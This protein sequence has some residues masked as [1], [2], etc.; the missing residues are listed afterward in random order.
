MNTNVGM[1]ASGSVTA[2]ISV[3]RTSRRNTM[4][5]TI[6]RKPPM[7]MASR[8]LAID[9]RD[10]L[11]QVVDLGDVECRRAGRAPDRQALR[12][13]PASASR[14]FAPICCEMLIETASRPLPVTS[15]V[16]S[17]EPGDDRA[18]VRHADGGAVLDDD[19]RG[20]IWSIERPQPGGEREVLL[21]RLGETSD[22]QQLVLRLQRVGDIGDRQAGGRSASRGSSTTSISRVSLASTSIWPAPGTRASSGRTT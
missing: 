2:A 14:M 22:R 18:E 9:A 10:E 5:T 11:R 1:T 16:R 7:R 19:R 3:S 15:S 8:T 6:A 12:R 4:R 17:G 13:R 20:A 21:A